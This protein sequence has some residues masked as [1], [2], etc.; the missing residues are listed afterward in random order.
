ML[1]AERQYSSFYTRPGQVR[2][3]GL[4]ENDL[5]DLVLAVWL[6]Q[7]PRHHP[8]GLLCVSYWVS[9]KVSVI[10]QLLE[11]YH[12]FVERGRIRFVGE[13]LSAGLEVCIG[14]ATA[15]LMD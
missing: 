11:R 4:V 8:L 3:T 13:F 2:Q 9:L 14:T 10:E 6:S 7:R 5:S 1:T 12:R 15:R